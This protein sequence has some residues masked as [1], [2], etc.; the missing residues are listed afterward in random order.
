[1]RGKWGKGQI[2]LEVEGRDPSGLFKTSPGFPI[3][4][5]Q[6]L[7]N[8]SLKIKGILLEIQNFIITAKN[9]P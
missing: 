5:I 9:I 4:Q 7:Q 6:I 3:F 8:E 1:M 2:H